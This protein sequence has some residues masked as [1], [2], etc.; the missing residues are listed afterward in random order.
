MND[1]YTKIKIVS[2]VII[3]MSYLILTFIFVFAKRTTF[4]TY[5]N[6]VTKKMPK[7]SFNSL[8]DT[9]Y[10]KSIDDYIVDTIPFRDYFLDK[11]NYVNSLRGMKNYGNT[12]MLDNAEEFGFDE[13]T[14]SEN[15]NAE[16]IDIATISNLNEYIDYSNYCEYE[17]P[18]LDMSVKGVIILSD[19]KTIRAMAGPG[20]WPK[21][22]SEY[23]NVVNKY[24]DFFKQFGIKVYT[25]IV[26]LSVAYYA[27]KK[28][29]MYKENTLEA[30]EYLS[31]FFNEDVGQV[32]VYNAL[33]PHIK[34]DIYLRTDHHWASLGAYYASE[35]FAKMAQVDFKPLTYYDK[36]EKE[37]FCGTIYKTTGVVELKEIGETFTY[38]EPNSVDYVSY[39]SDFVIDENQKVATRSEFKEHKYFMKNLPEGTSLYLTFMGGDTNITHVKTNNNTGRNLL[40]LKDSNG[41]AV[42]SNLFYSFDNIYI[43][44]YRYF[45]DNFVHFVMNSEITDILF[46]N[47]I[48]A[49]K[50]NVGAKYYTDLL[51]CG[52]IIN[53]EQNN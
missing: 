13:K 35:A 14:N 2:I 12:Y 9:S 28:Y 49:C 37:K 51:Y 34:E 44:D 26:P 41:N 47:S 38:Y 17:N 27:P 45:C 25:M 4:S 5:E 43:V 31:Q 39:R 11:S 42:A 32:D 1:K 24:S 36:H 40:I 19:G 7:Y 53:N 20:K 30:M 29:S 3:S 10:L 52:Q 33:L 16:K 48:S 46:V 8:T 6:R 22:C 15:K 23:A 50:A 18:T 21:N